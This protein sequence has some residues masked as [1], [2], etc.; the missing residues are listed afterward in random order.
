[1]A[2]VVSRRPLTAEAR[3][4]PCGI[5]G[6]QS[7]TATGLSPSSSVSPVDIIPPW[8]STHTYIPGGWTTGPLVAAVQRHCPIQSTWTACYTSQERSNTT[9]VHVS[10]LFHVIILWCCINCGGYMTSNVMRRGTERWHQGQNCAVR[11]SVP[12][13]VNDALSETERAL[14]YRGNQHNSSGKVTRLGFKRT[15]SLVQAYSSITTKLFG[16]RTGCAAV[17]SQQNFLT[18][19]WKFHLVLHFQ[20]TFRARLIHRPEDGGSMHLWNVGILQRDYRTLYPRKLSSSY[21][22]PWEPE[23]SHC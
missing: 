6:G 20:Q 10:H 2:Q 7:G 22:P 19:W 9:P 8:L 4:S 18:V 11:V 5:C 16:S 1:M 21:S 17:S 23:I 3:V 13:T 15:A 14:R 12:S